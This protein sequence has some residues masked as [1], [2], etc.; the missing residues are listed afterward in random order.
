[1]QLL[2]HRIGDEGATRI[3][4]AVA[5][6]P[7]EL[8]YIFLLCVL[9]YPILQDTYELLYWTKYVRCELTR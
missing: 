6:R 2:M 3:S 7:K 8:V 4:R 5:D 9:M 1:M